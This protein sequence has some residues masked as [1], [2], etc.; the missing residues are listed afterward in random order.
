MPI[1]T[2][3]NPKD[4]RT[5]KKAR[6]TINQILESMEN[7]ADNDFNGDLPSNILGIFNTLS[8]DDKRTFLRRSL[9]ALWEKRITYA[10]D[11]LQEIVLA[12]DITA[13]PKQPGVIRKEE[14]RISPVEVRS[15]RRSI[16]S[17]SPEEQKRLRQW[18]LKLLLVVMFIVFI[19]I[20]FFTAFYG[21][22]DAKT[23]FE[24]A[25][26][27]NTLIELLLKAN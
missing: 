16:E 20:L 3:T 25:G 12:G 9:E 15:E 10:Q 8:T 1:K 11:G 27:I 5:V 13:D 2:P 24:A 21:T 17:T 14:V 26:S 22:Y 18:A 6:L 19:G 23:I 7:Q 4:R